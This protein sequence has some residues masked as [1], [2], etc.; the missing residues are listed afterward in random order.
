MWNLDLP[1]LFWGSLRGGKVYV[2]EY[3]INKYAD[4]LAKRKRA[5]QGK[6]PHLFRNKCKEKRG[7]KWIK[8]GVTK[9]DTENSAVTQNIKLQGT[10]E[11]S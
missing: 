7:R 10:E 2:R 11:L 5:V 9:A 3:S 4:Y 6:H 8:Q 1:V